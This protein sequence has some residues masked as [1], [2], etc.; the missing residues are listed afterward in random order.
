MKQFEL[1]EACFSGLL[2]RAPTAVELTEFAGKMNAGM[3]LK[4]L[5]EALAVSPEFASGRPSTAEF[6]PPGHFYSALPADIVRNRFCE[7][8]GD[9]RTRT[10]LPGI[11]INDSTAFKHLQE[12]A[13]HARS[14]PFTAHRNP[15]HRYYFENPAYSY[16]DG[17][18]LYAMIRT[19]SPKR[20]IE[21][22][23]GFSSALMLDVNELHFSGNIELSFIEPYPEL[24]TSLFHEGDEE[25]CEV[26]SR[27]VQEVSPETFDKLERN[28]IL[29]IDST[30]VSKLFSDVNFLYF[31]VLPRLK[32]GVRV[33]IHDIFWPFEYPV[34]WISEKRSWNECYL[35]RSLLTCTNKF[36]IL[37]FSDLVR[38]NHEAWIMENVPL[39]QR[40]F[41]GH[42]WF[43]VD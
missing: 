42:I 30:H 21:V 8:F 23:S 25:T 31:E 41:G 40:N 15:C 19:L 35:L 28:D 36:Q 13:A 18:S 6:V 10:G 27:P 9:L 24:L 32:A 17:L 3:H 33:H 16:G 7:E 29:F 14:C 1:I 5:I 34:E 39:L 4:E 26:I 12:I 2:K 11:A 43:L 20:I 37:Y 38:L 22:G